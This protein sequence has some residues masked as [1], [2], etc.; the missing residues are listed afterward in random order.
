MAAFV[1]TVTIGGAWSWLET[2]EVE[3]TLGSYSREE[4]Q[5]DKPVLG[6]KRMDYGQGCRFA[7]NQELEQTALKMVAALRADGG[8]KR[9]TADAEMTLVARGHAMDMI[10]KGYFG[11]YD[12][13]GKDVGDRLLEA[14]IDYQVVGENLAYAGNVQI[15]HDG[16][17]NSRSHLRV[18]RDDRFSR[19][20]IGVV[21]GGRCG[22][23]EVQTFAN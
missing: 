18:M 21:D 10:A 16:L 8:N 12:L 20:G 22:I 2:K 14:A 23:V 15:A 7:V 1:A 6:V 4:Q 5:D 9:L 11:H 3:L 13:E 19:V 17:V